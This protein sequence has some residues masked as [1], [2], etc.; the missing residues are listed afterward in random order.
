MGFAFGF[1]LAFVLGLLWESAWAI[2]VLLF[3]SLAS[4]N[5]GLGSEAAAYVFLSIIGAVNLYCIPGALRFASKV[6]LAVSAG[7]TQFTRL[8]GQARGW[9]TCCVVSSVVC[10][11]LILRK[12]ISDVWLT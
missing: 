10:G 6:G 12:I 11:V 4:K 7:K 8:L 1:A 5:L 2:G 9:A 3:L